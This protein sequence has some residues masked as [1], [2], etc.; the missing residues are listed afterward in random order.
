VQIL[1]KGVLI[2]IIRN[3]MKC[4]HCK[5]DIEREDYQTINYNKKEFRI[6]KWEDKKFKDFPMPKGYTWAEYFDVVELV[7]KEKL[8]FTKPNE[9]TYICKNPFKQNKKYCLSGLYLGYVLDL[10]SSNSGLEYSDDSGRVVL[11]KI[12]RSSN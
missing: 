10:Y 12:K 4:P 7:N 9:E 6:Y 8:E 5:K 1:Q 11:V 3:K 2:H